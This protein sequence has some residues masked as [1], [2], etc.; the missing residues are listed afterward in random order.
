MRIITRGF[1][2]DSSLFISVFIL[3]SAMARAWT[4]GVSNLRNLSGLVGSSQ[5]RSRR[6]IFSRLSAGIQNQIQTLISIEDCVEASR[7]TKGV[8]FVDG[9]WYHRG[10]QNGRKE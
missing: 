3:V 6:R 7:N 9:S 1:S 5:F 8:V 10:S 2:N 4:I